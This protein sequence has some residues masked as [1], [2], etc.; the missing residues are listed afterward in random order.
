MIEKIAVFI[1]VH[2]RPDKM[3]T[4]KSLRQSGYTGKIF[5]VADDL[6]ETMPLYKEKYGEN[7]IVFDKKEA[8]KE[9]DAG[10]NSGDLRSTLFASSHIFKIAKDMNIKYFFIMCDDYTLFAYKFDENLKFKETKI[11]NFDRVFQIMIDF[12]VSSNAAC[13]AMA[14]NGDFIGGKNSKKAIEKKPFRKAMNTFL[15]STDRPF[16][17]MG[18]LN[19]DVTTYVN[20]GSKG[21][22]FLTLP[23]VAIIQLP[24]QKVAGGLSE[25]YLRYGTYIKSFFS[26]MFNPSC[27]KI[28]MMG[29]SHKRIHHSVKWNNAVPKIISEQYKKAEN[30]NKMKG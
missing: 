22:L 5:Y 26:V 3:W 30:L 15:C 12:L 9:V 2:G 11:K 20:L 21:I 19:E 13:V 28:G 6:D 18:R 1:M 8:A 16:K 14:Q 27:V 23:D 17:F 25:V 24:T 29:E 7:L 4:A 10:D